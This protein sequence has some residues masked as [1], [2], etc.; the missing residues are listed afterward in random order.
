MHTAATSRAVAEAAG[1]GRCEQVLSAD[2][3][4]W[5]EAL[6]QFVRRNA[7]ARLG[8]A[9]V[10]EQCVLRR[11]TAAYALEVCGCE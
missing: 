10:Y 1:Q 6:V 2:P 11:G 8:P 3:K 5:L 7:G 4:M 9:G